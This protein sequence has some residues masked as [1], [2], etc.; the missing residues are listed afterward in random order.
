MR[1]ATIHSACATADCDFLEP[2]YTELL[3]PGRFMQHLKAEK[4][5]LFVRKLDIYKFYN[6]LRL[7]GYLRTCLELPPI[8]IGKDK[9]MSWPRLV[10]VLMG[11]SLSVT[12]SQGIHG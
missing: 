8:Y 11:W 12:I 2:E 3:H 6:L 9:E 10:T 1:K 4:V 5:D 7:P